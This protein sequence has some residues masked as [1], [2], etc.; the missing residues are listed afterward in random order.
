[1]LMFGLHWG[2]HTARL[3]GQGLLGTL[4][5]LSPCDGHLGMEA[6]RC[7]NFCLLRSP[8]GVSLEIES[9]K[10]YIRDP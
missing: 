2:K 1:M 8:Q 10:S 9:R 5:L 7:C 6:S 4:P 3:V